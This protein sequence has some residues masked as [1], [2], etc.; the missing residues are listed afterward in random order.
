MS[1]NV[2][3]VPMMSQEQTHWCWAAVAAAIS[4]YDLRAIPKEQCAIV[5]DVVGD[6]AA[7]ERPADVNN[8]GQLEDAIAAIG[9]SAPPGGPAMFR[10]TDLV[11]NIEKA[12]PVG[13]RILDVNDGSA[14]NILLVGCDEQKGTVVC[15]D[16]WGHVGLPAPLY[17]MEFD[18]FKANYGD[19][20]ICTH[21]FVL[22]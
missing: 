22:R 3:S 15:A 4:I 10:L 6:P 12:L 13:A 19:W 9:L 5:G 14:H 1:E 17:R 18:V 16:P 21:V 11:H 7:C 20:G 2:L 8:E